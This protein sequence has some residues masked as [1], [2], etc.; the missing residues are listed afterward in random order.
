MKWISNLL[1]RIDGIFRVIW[2]NLEMNAVAFSV[3]LLVKRKK[4][5]LNQDNPGSMGSGQAQCCGLE[6]LQ[7]SLSPWSRKWSHR[8]DLTPNSPPFF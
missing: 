6:S 3:A 1:P 4:Y 8:D 5:L 7:T 2:I